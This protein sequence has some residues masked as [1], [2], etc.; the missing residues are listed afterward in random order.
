MCLRANSLTFANEPSQLTIE[1]GWIYIYFFTYQS[2]ALAAEHIL[3]DLINRY[4]WSIDI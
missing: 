1:K 2:L 4:G 3:V